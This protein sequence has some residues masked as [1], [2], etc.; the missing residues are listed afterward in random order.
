MKKFV[1]IIMRQMEEAN[2]ENV[3][4]KW[5]PGKAKEEGAMSAGGGRSTGFCPR[6]LASPLLQS[7]IPT[8]QFSTLSAPVT[9]QSTTPAASRPA[10]VLRV[11]DH[12]LQIASFGRVGIWYF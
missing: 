1:R 8:S 7:S 12:R 2:A 6:T 5:R 4:C 11:L 3:E 9:T 10:A